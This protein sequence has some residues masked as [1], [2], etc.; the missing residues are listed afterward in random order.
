MEGFNFDID[1]VKKRSRI[2]TLFAPFI[3]LPL[4]VFITIWAVPHS[5]DFISDFFEDYSYDISTSS[6]KNE[7]ITA[8][9]DSIRTKD[10]NLSE[11]IDFIYSF[12]E[13]SVDFVR[14]YTTYLYAYIADNYSHNTAIVLTSLFI[15]FSFWAYVTILAFNI[16][17]FFLI[18]VPVIVFLLATKR[19]PSWIYIWN[20]QITMYLLRLACYFLS[21][22]PNFPSVEKN[23]GLSIKFPNPKGKDLN[24]I[25]PIIK[26]L[27]VIPHS[28]IL[29][30]LGFLFIPLSFIGYLVTIITGE[31]P[32]KIFKFLVGYL[33]WNYR[34][35]CYAN[36][37]STDEYPQYSLSKSKDS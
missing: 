13:I 3:V 32:R 21:L 2:K 11:N 5:S 29:I 15:A 4:I 22:T 10:S 35:F 20:S 30:F 1:Y 28:L 26:W 25:L 9:D 16:L 7:F 14:S 12:E 8:M 23:K 33:R 19:Y 24:R 18:H 6:G 27:L 34:V 31:Y 37:L 17:Y 36:L